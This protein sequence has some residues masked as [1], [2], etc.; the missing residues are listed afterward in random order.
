MITTIDKNKKQNVDA[1]GIKIQYCK[2]GETSGTLSPKSKFNY[3]IN[4]KGQKLQ[5]IKK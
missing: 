5:R 2:P 1:T 3:A 4:K